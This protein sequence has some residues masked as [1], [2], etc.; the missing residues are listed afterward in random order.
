[1]CETYEIFTVD[2]KCMNVS[3]F[4]DT[5]DSPVLSATVEIQ[6]CWLGIGPSYGASYSL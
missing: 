2:K 6:T 3:A 5:L 4:V 1:M